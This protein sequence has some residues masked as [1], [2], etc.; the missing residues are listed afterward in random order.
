MRHWCAILVLWA[1][2]AAQ[3]G[4][5]IPVEYPAVVAG[6]EL[7]FPRDHGAHPTFRTEWWYVTG[8]LVDD[9]GVER[10]FQITFFRVRTGIGATSASIAG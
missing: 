10:G 6:T 9:K 1:V 5:T 3:S 2:S 8:W 7:V 4:E